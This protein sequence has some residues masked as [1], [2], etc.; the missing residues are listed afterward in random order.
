ML[1]MGFDLI[2]Y[3]VEDFGVNE[4]FGTF[5]LRAE[6]ACQITYACDLNIYFL[7]RFQL[8]VPILLRRENSP[9]LIYDPAHMCHHYYIGLEGQGKSTRM[10]ISFLSSIPLTTLTYRFFQSK[11]RMY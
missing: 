2:Q 8:G 11:Y 1:G 9:T 3:I 4:I 5:G 7:E 10:L 6:A